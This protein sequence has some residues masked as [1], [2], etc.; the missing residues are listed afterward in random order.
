MRHPLPA[1]RAGGGKL[2][3]T[4]RPL[5]SPSTADRARLD[6]PQPPNYTTV[7]LT[8]GDLRPHTP[9]P[10]PTLL[11]CYR[12]SS[13]GGSLYWPGNTTHPPHG[14]RLPTEPPPHPSTRRDKPMHCSCP[15]GALDPPPPRLWPQPQPIPTHEKNTNPPK[16]PPYK[17]ATPQNQHPPTTAPGW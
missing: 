3:E 1:P 5:P 11:N 7:I 12:F 2:N 17:P 9:R 13:F 14:C 10:P 8:V 16:P 15:H 6:S 4:P